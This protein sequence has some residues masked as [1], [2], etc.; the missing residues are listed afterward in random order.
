MEYNNCVALYLDLMAGSRTNGMRK[1]NP[2]TQRIAR[3][4]RKRL[5]KISC[6]WHSRSSHE[7]A[8]D[9]WFVRWLNKTLIFPICCF[10][11]FSMT[12]KIYSN[13]DCRIYLNYDLKFTKALLLFVEILQSLQSSSTLFSDNIQWNVKLSFPCVRFNN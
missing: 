11:V 8:A 12:W 13:F 3:V 4:P 7:K 2:K 6:F 9:P 10:Y 1:R 5:R